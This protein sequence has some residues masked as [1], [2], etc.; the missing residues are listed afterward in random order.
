MITTSCIINGKYVCNTGPIQSVGI[1][2]MFQNEINKYTRTPN[3]KSTLF[4]Q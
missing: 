3:D 1:K 4:V 2:Q